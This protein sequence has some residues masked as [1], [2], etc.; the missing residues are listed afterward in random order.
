MSKQAKVMVL[1]GFAASLATAGFAAENRCG[2]YENPS[3]GNQWLKDKDATW[4][5][6]S[7]GE[8]EGPDAIGREKI[9]D[10]TANREQYVFFDPNSYQGYACACM[11]V[12]VDRKAERITRIHSVKQLPLATCKA[13]R[14]LPKPDS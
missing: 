14:A 1:A 12:D 9:P 5:I 2:W 10:F 3:T 7:Q 4:I 8:A 6:T 11:V 13:D